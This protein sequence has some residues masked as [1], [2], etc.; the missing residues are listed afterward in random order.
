MSNGLKWKLAVGFLLVFF[1]GAATGSFAWKWHRRPWGPPQAGVLAERIN[2]RLRHELDLTPAQSAKIAP[3]IE[4]SAKKL[5]TIRRESA[6][7][8][9]QT[10]AETHQQISPELTP[11]QRKKLA[12]IEEKHRRHQ[13]RH[14]GFPGPQPE[15]SPSPSP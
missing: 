1:A 8:V 11:E 12:A 6:R 10:L 14:H 3:L 9:R 5:E 4:Q 7:R 15:E 13:G 2:D